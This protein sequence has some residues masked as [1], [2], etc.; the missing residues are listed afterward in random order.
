[1]RTGHLVWRFHT[2]P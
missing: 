1:M 2:I